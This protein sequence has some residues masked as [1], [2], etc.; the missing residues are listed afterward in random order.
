MNIVKKTSKYRGV[1]LTCEIDASR[2]WLKDGH[3]WAVGTWEERGE[4]WT[5]SAGCAV[6]WVLD[7]EWCIYERWSSI[8]AAAAFLTDYAARIRAKAARIYSE[9]QMHGEM[10]EAFRGM[11]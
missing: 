9:A 3:E 4:D 11:I 2:V 10:A 6:F 8:D 7:G 1:T 5:M